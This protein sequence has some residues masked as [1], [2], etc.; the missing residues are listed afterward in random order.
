MPNVTT[1]GRR[2]IKIALLAVGVAGA[3]VLVALVTQKGPPAKAGGFSEYP[4]LQSN[5][6]PGLTIA[7]TPSE[8]A[9]AAGP[10]FAARVPDAAVAA[11]RPLADTIRPVEDDSATL[12]TWIARNAE[13]GV[14]VLASPKITSARAPLAYSCSTAGGADSGAMLE[15][16]KSVSA[17]DEFLYAG[18]VPAGV[19]SVTLRLA[20]GSSVTAP[21]RDGGWSAEAKARARGIEQEVDGAAHE[22][23]EGE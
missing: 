21:V 12:A 18:V 5:S 10:A 13:G 15:M 2:A 14:C 17:Q 4:A 19:S 3:A 22:S 9:A 6:G 20:D 7:S 1:T 8:A 16:T 23:V 11:R